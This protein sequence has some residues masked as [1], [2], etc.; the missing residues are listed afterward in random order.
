MAKH[1]KFI[2]HTG[3]YTSGEV[4]AF[5]DAEADLLVSKKKAVLAVLSPEQIETTK[6]RIT[7]LAKQEESGSHPDRVAELKSLS[8]FVE[9]SEKAHADA[10]AA[11]EK[12]AAEAEKPKEPATPV[13][14]N[15]Q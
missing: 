3:S 4:A 14:P 10:K 12:A 13:A 2:E 5:P 9:F 7:F 11:A 15:A 1:V 6:A 8:D